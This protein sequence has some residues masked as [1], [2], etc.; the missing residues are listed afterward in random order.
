MEIIELEEDEKHP[1]REPKELPKEQ[2]I[3]NI[4]DKVSS[5]NPLGSD[6]EKAAKE[7]VLTRFGERGCVK[8][9]W[10]KGNKT[11][12][13]IKTKTGLYSVTLNGQNTVT[14]WD[15]S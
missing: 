1:D 4:F 14:D 15:K 8:R 7:F 11:H 13:L 9:S 3:F 10:Q 12:V 2:G 6:S 5:L